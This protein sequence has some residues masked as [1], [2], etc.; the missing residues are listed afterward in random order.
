MKE[1][2]DLAAFPPLYPVLLDEDGKTIDGNHRLARKKDW[3]KLKVQGIKGDK[4]RVIARMVANGSRRQISRKE[5][6]GWA[7]ELAEILLHEGFEPGGEHEEG[8]TGSKRGITG[9]I[10]FLTGWDSHVVSRLLSKRYKGRRKT[11]VTKN[12]VVPSDGGAAQSFASLKSAVVAWAK[13]LRANPEPK[14]TPTEASSG[15]V[16]AQLTS[17]SLVCPHCNSAPGTILWGCCQKPFAE[18]RRND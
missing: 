17:G 13:D 8:L 1:E 3:P 2:Y 7:N 14:T 10:A 9:E 5:K 6:G 16:S 18:A 11:T 15:F 12:T 4:L